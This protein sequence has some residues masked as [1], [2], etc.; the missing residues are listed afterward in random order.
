MSCFNFLRIFCFP[1]CYNAVVR[2]FAF[3]PPKCTYKLAKITGT[4]N[5]YHMVL[6]QGKKPAYSEAVRSIECYLVETKRKNRIVC[7]YVKCVK[8]PKFTILFSHANACDLGQIAK[9]LLQLGT[10]LQCN[11][12][13]Y[14]YSGYGKS[15]GVPSEKHIYSDIEAVL[16]SMRKRY[17]I[18]DNKVIAYGWSIGCAPTIHLASKVKLRAVVIHSGFTSGMDVLCRS[19]GKVKWCCNPFNS[20]DKVPKVTSPVLVIHGMEDEVIDFAHGLAIYERC[21]RAVEPL[22]VEGAGHNDVE[23]Y[24]QYVERLKQFVSVELV[25]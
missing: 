5:T 17:G 3:H 18:P 14:D 8:E 16:V 7:M 2:K 1:P 19:D 23:L 6:R 11:I 10:K 15:T 13:A 4:R 20:I 21:P 25:N 9:S 22:W 12:V 24:G